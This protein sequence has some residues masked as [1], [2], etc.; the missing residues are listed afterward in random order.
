MNALKAALLAAVL[1]ALPGCGCQYNP[2]AHLMTNQKPTAA[3]V[4][5][6][7]VYD[8][9][10]LPGN[11]PNFATVRTCSIQLNA[12]GTYTAVHVASS[13]QSVSNDPNALKTLYD[14]TGIWSV[15]TCGSVDDGLGNLKNAWGVTLKDA[16][17]GS[18]VVV[19]LIGQAPPY[20]LMTGLGDGDEGVAIFLK[21]V[22]TTAA[23]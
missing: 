23:R 13:D 5:G 20:E 12:D 3:N 21:K 8:R 17:S 1:F 16:K 18:G 7:Y 6:Y 22:S 2:H 11:N 4:A 19:S 14:G 15:D 10:T 9:D